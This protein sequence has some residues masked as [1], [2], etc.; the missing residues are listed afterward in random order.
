MKYLLTLLFT[1]VI[2]GSGIAATPETPAKVQFTLVNPT[3]IRW[4]VK[5]GDTEAWLANPP[6]KQFANVVK[7]MTQYHAFKNRIAAMIEQDDNYDR[8]LDRLATQMSATGIDDN[9]R[10][11]AVRSSDLRAKQNE[12]K[13]QFLT[14]QREFAAFRTKN[15]GD[16]FEAPTITVI[17]KPLDWRIDQKPVWQ[18]V[19]LVPA[20]KQE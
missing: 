15:N 8:E 19:G 10:A 5:Q 11:I 4:Q 7:R 20:A 1:A 3:G 17:A 18:F 14:V 13:R 2:G 9:W 12:L 16:A 6:A